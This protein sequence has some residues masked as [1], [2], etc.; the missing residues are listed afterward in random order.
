[1]RFPRLIVSAENPFHILATET[2]FNDLLGHPTDELRYQTIHALTGPLTDIVLLQS[3]I[4]K[5]AVGHSSKVQLVIYDRLGRGARMMLQFFQNQSSETPEST[6]LCV[7]TF[8]TSDAILLKEAVTGRRCAQTVVSAEW[9]HRVRFVSDGFTT[10]FRYTPSQTL[11]S[12]ISIIRG[13][14]TDVHS[15]CTLLQTAVNGRMATANL[16]LRTGEGIDVDTLVCCIPAVEALNGPVTHLLVQL[17]TL[18]PDDVAALDQIKAPAVQYETYSA[19]C[20]EQGSTRSQSPEFC[21]STAAESPA[22]GALDTPPPPRIPAS[23]AHE[24]AA[25]AEAAAL[26]G[27][28]DA[29]DDS[30]R[31]R[32]HTRRKANE[33]AGST[34]TRTPSRPL[35]LTRALLDALAAAH[36][37]R[38]AAARLGMSQTS[39]KAA[40]RK[41]GVSSWPRR[42]GPDYRAAAAVALVRK[43]RTAA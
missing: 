24:A 36:P 27:G 29:T 3:S 26:N 39:L 25:A 33:A 28:G 1:M 41:L 10:A 40:C 13:P 21:S 42:R 43:L 6:S 38:R 17:Q 18:A 31:L 16:C 7:I 20:S 15:W 5:T 32:I 19:S 22:D 11:G 4:E 34:R 30:V 35:T 12:N 8:E 2:G 37:L 14:G 23:E 9:P